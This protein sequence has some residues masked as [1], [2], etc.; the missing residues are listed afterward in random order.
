MRTDEQRDDDYRFFQKMLQ[1]G[2][3]VNDCEA[4]LG[5]ENPEPKRLYRREA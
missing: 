3:P 4:L 1:G 2:H 5:A